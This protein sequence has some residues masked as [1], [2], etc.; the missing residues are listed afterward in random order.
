MENSKKCRTCKEEIN[1]T[2]SWCP[3]CHRPQSIFRAIFPPQAFAILLIGF[4]GYWYLT[5]QAME[6]SLSQFTSAAVYETTAFLEVSETSIQIKK[7]G[8]ESCVT[9]LGKITNKSDQA[10]GSIHFEVTY[11]NSD[12]SVIDVV[13]D[14]DNDLV[15]GPKAEGRFRVK[16]TSSAEPD[17]Y[18][19]SEVKITK[20]KPDTSWY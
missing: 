13:N 10:Y 12:D 7:E 4:G 8:C 1:A 14:E 19:R 16:A 6:D 18:T 20:A 11:Y 17:Q 5:N 3:K 15:I 9:T 2:A